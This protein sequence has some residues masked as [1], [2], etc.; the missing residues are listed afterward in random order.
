MTAQAGIRDYRARLE[1]VREHV[2]AHLDGPL[3]LDE[4]ADV[5]CLSRFP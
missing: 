1:R 4:L 5:A 2:R 3:N